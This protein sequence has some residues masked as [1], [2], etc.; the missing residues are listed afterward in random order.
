MNSSQFVGIAIEL[1]SSWFSHIS[2]WWI[3]SLTPPH[4]PSCHPDLTYFPQES[5]QWNSLQ[6]I[7][8]FPTLSELADLLHDGMCCFCQLEMKKRKGWKLMGFEHEKLIWNKD[9]TDKTKQ[10]KHAFS[11]V[12]EFLNHRNAKPGCRV[13]NIHTCNRTL[14]NKT[15]HREL[16]T[17]NPHYVPLSLLCSIF[18]V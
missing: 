8:S 13:N 14:R 6:T 16:G 11:I 18:C 15:V 7:V 5:K 10:Q 4:P 9:T 3:R 2:L 1:S 12:L 17:G